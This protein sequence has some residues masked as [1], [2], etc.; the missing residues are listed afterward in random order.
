MLLLQHLPVSSFFACLANIMQSEAEHFV[1][2][3]FYI[4]GWKKFFMSN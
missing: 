2:L 3:T 1:T 4:L